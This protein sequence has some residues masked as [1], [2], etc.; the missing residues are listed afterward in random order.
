MNSWWYIRPVTML[1]CGP[2]P[3]GHWSFQQFVSWP[4]GQW[5]SVGGHWDDLPSIWCRLGRSSHWPGQGPVRKTS[6][7][8]TIP[9]HSR[10]NDLECNASG[11]LPWTLRKEPE[12]AD[13]DYLGF[14]IFI[15]LKWQEQARRTNNRY[16]NA[17][18]KR[19]PYHRFH[20]AIEWLTRCKIHWRYFK[21]TSRNTRS[22]RAKLCV[23]GARLDFLGMID[24]E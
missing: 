24:T 9:G 2:W 5:P 7:R 10:D 1:P 16:L 23:A 12:I 22:T 17:K 15:L 6:G 8:Q 4:L 21:Q 14:Y 19:K 13:F 18:S 3:P 20:L 11:Y